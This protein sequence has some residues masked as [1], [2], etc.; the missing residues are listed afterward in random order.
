MEDTRA[1]DIL[2]PALDELDGVSR[3]IVELRFG[4]YGHDR[5]LEETAAECGLFR[6]PVRRI[7]TASLKH[8]RVSAGP[9][10]REALRPDDQ[11]R[12]SDPGPWTRL[13]FAVYDLAV[14][15]GLEVFPARSPDPI[16]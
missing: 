5:T 7:E 3:R 10:L 8:I 4:L 6:E 16:G 12:A 11:H 13:A 14:A 1:R 15:R 9:A 2:L